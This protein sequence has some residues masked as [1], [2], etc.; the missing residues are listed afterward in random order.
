MTR[1]LGC[2]A[3]GHFFVGVGLVPTL[4]FSSESRIIADDAEIRGFLG[5]LAGGHFL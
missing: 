4:P 1:S 2:L 3:G 5:C